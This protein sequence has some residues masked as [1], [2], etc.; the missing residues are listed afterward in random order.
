MSYWLQVQQLNQSYTTTDFCLALS[1]LAY[2]DPND[3]VSPDA[4][5]PLRWAL[6]EA[7]HTIQNPGDKWFW[8]A[9]SKHQPY[10]KSKDLFQHYL[11][12]VRGSK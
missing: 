2:L 4:S 9:P 8:K 7:D 1:A 10:L 5:T 12:T 3:Q 6:H 11:D